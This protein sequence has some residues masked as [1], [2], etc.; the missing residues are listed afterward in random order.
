M[1]IAK[2]IMSI[3]LTIT[4]LFTPFWYLLINSDVPPAPTI[5][6]IRII[7]YMFILILIFLILEIVIIEKN[8]IRGSIL[9]FA[10]GALSLIL[11]TA[12]Y[13]GHNFNI[14][15]QTINL[16]SL[17]IIL[18]GTI[19]SALSTFSQLFQI[20]LFYKRKLKSKRIGK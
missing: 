19:L 20:L 14:G 6:D 2:C 18:V 17:A 4:L 12:I 10:S 16:Y 8:K 13:Y 1:K 11:W 15:N 3:T 7:I 9:V 5:N